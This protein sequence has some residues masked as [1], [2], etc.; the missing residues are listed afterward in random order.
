MR[1]ADRLFAI[2][3]LLR[4]RRLTTAAMLADRFEVSER[5]IY[6]DIQDLVCS[7][8]PIIG[9]AGLGYQLRGYDL[10]P[11]MFTEEEIEAVVLGARVVR[12]WADPALQRAADEALDKIETVLPDRLRQRVKQ[13]A[14]FALNFQPDD[15]GIGALGPLRQAVREH[16]KIRLA[17]R[18]ADG[19]PSSRIVRPLCLAFIP[20]LWMLSAWCELRADFRNFRLDRI[21]ELEVLDETFADEPGRSLDD[22]LRFVSADRDGPAPRSKPDG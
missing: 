17:Y 7:G 20:P 3:Q 9:E 13:S 11:L 1:R 6:R 12:R 4:R 10:P 22:F 16:R 21:V 14:L 18:R 8:V 15:Q 5:T 19:Q 2:V